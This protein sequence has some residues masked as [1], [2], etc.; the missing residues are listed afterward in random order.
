MQEWATNIRLCIAYNFPTIQT[1]TAYHWHRQCTISA[2]QYSCISCLSANKLWLIVGLVYC[3]D[4]LI[5]Y[6]AAN[7]LHCVWLDNSACTRASKSHCSSAD[8]PCS[9]CVGCS[10]RFSAKYLV[11]CRVS[12]ALQHTAPYCVC[13]ASITAYCTAYDQ[14]CMRH[15]LASYH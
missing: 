1:S 4:A 12:S 11:D 10:S 7:N 15:A 6:V 3:L 14:H 9:Q 2:L 13:P 5:P 8:C